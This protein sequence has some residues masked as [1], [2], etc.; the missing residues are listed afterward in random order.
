MTKTLPVDFDRQAVMNAAA[1]G[2]PDTLRAVLRANGIRLRHLHGRN[3][4]LIGTIAVRQIDDDTFQVGF[5]QVNQ[6]YYRDVAKLRQQA[7]NLGLRLA[8][9]PPPPTKRTGTALALDALVNETMTV[10][11]QEVDF[12]VLRAIRDGFSRPRR[13]RAAEVVVFQRL[14]IILQALRAFQ[15]AGINVDEGE[16]VT[17]SPRAP[18]TKQVKPVLPPTP[19]VS[20]DPFF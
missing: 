3:G 4:S 2:A 13:N 10:T 7:R 14:R 16:E 17:C 11:R 19:E 20:T 9:V 8:T 15:R 12:D 1:Y 18:T 6:R 5:S